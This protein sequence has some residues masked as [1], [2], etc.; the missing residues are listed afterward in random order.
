MRL[1]LSEETVLLLWVFIFLIFLI[2]TESRVFSQEKPTPTVWIKIYRIQAVDQ[3]EDAQAE[4]EA[5][6]HVYMWVWSGQRWI[7]ANGTAPDNQNDVV[8]NETYTFN[9]VGTLSPTFYIAL[10]EDDLTTA[11]DVADISAHQG[12]GYDNYNGT[13]LR[14]AE[15]EAVYDLRTNNFT[16]DQVIIEGGYYK[17]SGDYDD[18]LETDENDA[19][20][21]FSIWDSYE[22]P[23]ANAGPDQIVYV[24][25]KVNFDGSM[26]NASSG[27]SLVKYEWDFETDGL[28][29]SEGM[30]TSY[31]YHE[32]GRYNVSLIV[33]DDFGEKCV[34][35]A[36]ITVKESPF[37]EQPW[38]AFHVIAGLTMVAFI[39]VFLANRL[40]TRKTVKR[41]V[42]NG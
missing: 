22:L 3:I 41:T 17:T 7:G 13:L 1:R 33:T 34:D 14:G 36:T 18:S 21:W 25:R 6:W 24:N 29:D 2:F 39:L 12:G 31:T 28:I 42:K 4:D 32:G 37:Y 11:S 8:L 40:K 38:F 23:A 15:F 30:R 19:N 26:S 9:G 20:L 27:S 16:G 10:L 35:T 5:E